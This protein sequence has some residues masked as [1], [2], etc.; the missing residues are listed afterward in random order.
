MTG[1][2]FHPG[3]RYISI[4]FPFFIPPGPI[5][6][7]I[8]VAPLQQSIRTYTKQG[9]SK[10]PIKKYQCLLYIY[11]VTH[12][13]SSLVVT[14]IISSRR[15][16]RCRPFSPLQLEFHGASHQGESRTPS[17]CSHKRHCRPQSKSM[18]RNGNQ[19]IINVYSLDCTQ[20]IFGFP[21]HGVFHTAFSIPCGFATVDSR[22]NNNGVP[23]QSNRDALPVCVCTIWQI[24]AKGT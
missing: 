20:S 17:E 9:A 18:K 24:Q 12:K 15:I 2:R 11:N 1:P 6:S 14:S 13:S 21:S 7:A 3:D 5:L 8:I 4:C 10:I 16:I 19:S 23:L 22:R